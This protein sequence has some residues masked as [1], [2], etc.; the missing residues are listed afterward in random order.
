MRILVVDDEQIALD[1][2][3]EEIGSIVSTAETIG[4]LLPEQA[5]AYAKEHLCDIAFLDI[6]MP[7][8]SGITLAKRLKKTNPQ[9]NIIFVTAYR[10]YGLEAMELRASGYLLKPVNTEDIKRELEALRYPIC[11][12]GSGIRAVTFG[13]F[14]LLVDGQAVHFGRAKSKELLAYLVDRQ[15]G[16][17]TKRE[18]AAILF[19]DQEYNRSIQ[20]YINKIVKELEISLNDAGAAAVFVKKRN[21]YAVDPSQFTCDFYEYEKGDPAAINAYRGEYMTQYSWSELEVGKFFD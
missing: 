20:D 19:E 14:D 5:I 21:Y 10:E 11:N 4:F 8:M 9:L 13:Q 2:L 12:V 1:M 7:Q 15:G 6:E 17:V 16:G 3:V 18:V